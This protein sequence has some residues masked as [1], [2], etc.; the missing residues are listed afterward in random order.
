M[1]PD[2]AKLADRDRE[3]QVGRGSRQARA[4]ATPARLAVA[5]GHQGA[6]R[7]FVPSQS[8]S[9]SAPIFFLSLRFHLAPSQRFPAVLWARARA[10]THIAPSQ[11]C[12]DQSLVRAVHLSSHMCLLPFNC[13]LA[14]TVFPPKLTVRITLSCS[15]DRNK[16]HRPTSG[17]SRSAG[18]LDGPACGRDYDVGRAQ[19]LPPTGVAATLGDIWRQLQSQCKC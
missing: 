6:R 7:P 1:H 9:S 2:Q 15:T 18:E 11:I 17:P 10:R 19:L 4:L 16:I 14:S 13:H 3:A 12:A 8:S 5:S